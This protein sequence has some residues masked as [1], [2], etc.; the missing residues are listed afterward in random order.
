MFA[1]LGWLALVALVSAAFWTGIG[2]LLGL[3]E[4]PRLFG[5]VFVLTFV[6]MLFMSGAKILR[7]EG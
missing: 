5:V 3:S 4:L 1:R 7:G 2:W 6:V